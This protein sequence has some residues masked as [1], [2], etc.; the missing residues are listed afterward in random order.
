MAIVAVPGMR[1]EVSDGPDGL[2]FVVPAPRVWFAMVFLPLWIA[3]WCAGEFFALRTL[4]TAKGPELM[5]LIVWLTGWTVGGTFA[6]FTW[7][8]MLAGKERVVLKTGVIAHRYELFGLSV[9]KEYDLSQ[10]RNLRVSPQPLNP[11]GGGSGLRTWGI[12]GGL[13]A[14]DYGAR[15]IRVAG[16]IDESEGNM[17][18]QRIKARFSIPDSAG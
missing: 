10:V 6:I 18:V 1:T 2:T 11:W 7:I 17:I 5:F 4:V 3:G 16:S 9:G 13:V 15:T 8:W 12:G 14:F